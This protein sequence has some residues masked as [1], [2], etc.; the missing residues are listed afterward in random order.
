VQVASKLA[1]D[2]DAGLP[3]TMVE[4]E[5]AEAVEQSQSPDMIAEINCLDR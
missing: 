4:I 1:I 5:W 2:A 3:W